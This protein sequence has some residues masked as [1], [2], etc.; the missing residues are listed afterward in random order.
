MNK[1]VNELNSVLKGEEI[2]VQAYERFIRNLHDQQVLQKFEKIKQDHKN[3]CDIISA[4]IQDLGGQPN[5]GTGAAG[6]MSNIKMAVKEKIT[7]RGPAEI[8]KE[9][10]DGEDKGITMVE[11]I[12]K[13]DLDSESHAMMKDILSTDHQHLREMAKMISD[14]EL[15]Q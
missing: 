8:L 4:R 6:I 14:L 1:V 3:H 11:E 2:A 10:Y 9:A 13:G 12:I 5:N 15:K 7:D